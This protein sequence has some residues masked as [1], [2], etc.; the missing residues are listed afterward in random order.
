MKEFTFLFIVILLMGVPMAYAQETAVVDEVINAFNTQDM[1]YFEEH[2][3]EEVVWLDEDGHA[4]A[5]K[6]RVSRFIN[7]RL[8]VDE[9]RI[10]TRNVKVFT[11][12]DAAWSHFNYA[13]KVKG[14]TVI[15]GLGSAVFRKVDGDWQIALIHGAH[16]VLGMHN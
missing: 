5:G 12:N 13:I 8:M 1:A 4:I 14:N 7:R 6:E 9:Q 16:N 2:L 3:A 10:V 11:S 15:E